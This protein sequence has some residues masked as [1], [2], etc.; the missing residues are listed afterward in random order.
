M[1]AKLGALD[2]REEPLL[3]QTIYSL[4]SMQTDNQRSPESSAWIRRQNVCNCAIL[5][6]RQISPIESNKQISVLRSV[7]CLRL[8]YLTSG[9]AMRVVVLKPC[10]FRI[11]QPTLI[12]Y[13]SDA[14]TH[15]R[16]WITPATALFI[17]DNIILN[18]IP[19]NFIIVPVINVDGYE[20]TW[21]SDRLWRKN[22][23][24]YSQSKFAISEMPDR[25]NG[26]DLNRNYDINFGGEGGPA[27]PCLVPI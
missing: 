8:L 6:I 23:K 16:E 1:C 21:S 17:I 13:G 3:S 20:Y 5:S 15:A 11:I 4:G 19:Q 24:P 18:N 25:C 10:K 22:R 7:N 27:N 26:V 12:I 14:C 2:S 9:S